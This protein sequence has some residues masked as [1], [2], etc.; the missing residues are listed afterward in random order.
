MLT[1]ATSQYELTEQ[2]HKILA[3]LRGVDGW[4]SRKTLSRL[5]QRNT[6][7][8]NDIRLLNELADAGLV[9][10]K[11]RPSARKHMLEYL[12]R[13]KTEGQE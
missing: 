5:L 6:L 11:T 9:E 3:L 4:L 13:A 10:I 7:N 2:A 1:P 12:Y 8:P